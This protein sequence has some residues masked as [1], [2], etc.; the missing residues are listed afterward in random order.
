MNDFCVKFMNKVVDGQAATAFEKQ[1]FIKSLE[2]CH[3]RGYYLAFAKKDGPFWRLSNKSMERLE[4]QKSN[5]MSWIDM[6][7]QEVV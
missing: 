3:T 1:E 7:F 6:L 5:F 2:D 4:A